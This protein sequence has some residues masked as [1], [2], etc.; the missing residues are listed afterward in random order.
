MPG[1]LRIGVIGCGAMGQGHVSVWQSI[2]G[3]SITAVC[4]ADGS[5]AEE[6]ANHIG[7]KPYSDLD[8]M[9]DS[10]FVDAVDICT[11]SGMHADQGIVAA[12]SGKHVLCEKPLDLNIEK[13]DR[14]IEVC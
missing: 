12:N 10:G 4:D 6:T 7:A 13:V 8:S 2:A 5:R 9:L 11:P 14:L 1:E 3:A